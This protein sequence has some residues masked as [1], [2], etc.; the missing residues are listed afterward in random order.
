MHCVIS[1][2]RGNNLTM[3]HA[4]NLYINAP[5]ATEPVNNGN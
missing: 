2:P 5:P 4:I 1:E 3:Q